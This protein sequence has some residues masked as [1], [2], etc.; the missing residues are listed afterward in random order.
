VQESTV[1][2][3]YFD[4][5]L[6]VLEEGKLCQIRVKVFHVLCEMGLPTVLAVL[7]LCVVLLEPASATRGQNRVSISIMRYYFPKM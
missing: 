6:V 5:L 2:E 1:A 4:T 3:D 7:A